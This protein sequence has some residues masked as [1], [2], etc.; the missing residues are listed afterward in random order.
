[1]PLLINSSYSQEHS[2][3]KV[4]PNIKDIQKKIKKSKEIKWEKYIP[5]HENYFPKNNKVLDIEYQELVLL[6]PLIL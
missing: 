4:K 1:M 2:W 6:I 3:Q 5:N